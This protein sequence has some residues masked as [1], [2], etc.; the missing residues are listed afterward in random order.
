MKLLITTLTMIFI[1]FGANA[2]LKFCNQTEIEAKYFFDLYKKHSNIQELVKKDKIRKDKK[3]LSKD[4]E[5]N[6][7]LSEYYLKRASEI[8]NVYNALCKK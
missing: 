1:N 4:M 7:K 6:Q 2:N 8:S 3:Y 5:V